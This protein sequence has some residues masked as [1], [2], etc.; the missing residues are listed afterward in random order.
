VQESLRLAPPAPMIARMISEEV[1]LDGIKFPP[2]VECMFP[3]WKLHKDPRCVPRGRQPQTMTVP[4][5]DPCGSVCCS[6]PRSYAGGAGSTHAA[7]VPRESSASN[8]ACRGARCTQHVGWCGSW[9]KDAEKFYPLRFEQT[10][11]RGSFIPF[12]DG[13]RS[14]DSLFG[15]AAAV[16]LS[17]LFA[18]RP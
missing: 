13:P 18:V 6:A 11:V 16:P 7:E 15:D 2:G 17:C 1:T 9:W 12:S 5:S 4:C 8:G 3:A 14:A 10:P